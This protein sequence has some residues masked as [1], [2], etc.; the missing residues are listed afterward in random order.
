MERCGLCPNE[1]AY[2]SIMNV[3]ARARD[4]GR[5]ELWFRNMEEAGVQPDHVAYN[6]MINAYD[7]SP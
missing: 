4:V 5:A 6:I 1:K 2:S 7:M 3:Y